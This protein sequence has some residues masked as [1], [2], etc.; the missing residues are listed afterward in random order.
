MAVVHG[1]LPI[2]KAIGNYLDWGSNMS[3][4]PVSTNGQRL[5]RRIDLKIRFLH[6]TGC[7]IASS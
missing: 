3:V 5:Q 6:S 1:A 7:E 4:V 2:T